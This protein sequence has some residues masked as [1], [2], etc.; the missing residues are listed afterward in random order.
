MGKIIPEI[1]VGNC[2]PLPQ[3]LIWLRMNYSL[4]VSTEKRSVELFIVETNN[5]IYE[6]QWQMMKILKVVQRLPE[7]VVFMF[8]LCS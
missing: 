5:Y 2:K 4:D 8:S 1:K 6:S 3:S 7:P